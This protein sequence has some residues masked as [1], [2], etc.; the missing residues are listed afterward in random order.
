MSKTERVELRLSPDDK[1]AINEAAAME[2]TSPTEF[3]RQ[4]VL[5]RAQRVHVRAERT[6][7][8]AEQ[9][10]ALLASLDV[11]DKA[12]SLARAFAHKRRFVQR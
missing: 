6:L 11:P 1:T 10:D 12:P 4:A 3:M 7:M 8:P 9:F 2:Q 5:D